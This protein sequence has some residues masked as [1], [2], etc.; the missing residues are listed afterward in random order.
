MHNTGVL[1]NFC[2]TEVHPKSSHDY[3]IKA[4]TGPKA[5]DAKTK[6]QLNYLVDVKGKD[7]KKEIIIDFMKSEIERAVEKS[8]GCVIHCMKSNDIE[9]ESVPLQ[10]A[11]NYC[12][13]LPMFLIVISKKKI[14][15]RCFV[16]K[17]IF[18]LI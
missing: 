17:V 18:K 8:D 14:R 1:K 5:K 13:N 11:Y 2:I 3:L 4:V 7:D 9:P 12:G 15:A 16:P 10:L 6:R